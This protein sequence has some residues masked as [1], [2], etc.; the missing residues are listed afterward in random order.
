[1]AQTE[2]VPDPDVPG[3]SIVEVVTLDPLGDPTNVIISSIPATISSSSSSSTT[4]P[5]QT[6]AIAPINQGPVATPPDTTIPF[7]EGTT[8]YT[9]TTVLDGVTE[10]LS[11]FFTPTF[12]TLSPP[13][14]ATSGSIMAL[15]EWSSIVGTN[16]VGVASS[17]GSW[18]LSSGG[19]GSIVFVTVGVLAGAYVVL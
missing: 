6:A 2:T 8:A 3:G 15:S 13:S 18:R 11:D 4:T 16:T 14:S 5:T 17:A 1:M 19:L 9:Y 10:T 12:N 7:G